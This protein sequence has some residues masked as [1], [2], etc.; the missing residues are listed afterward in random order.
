MAGPQAT[1]VIVAPISAVAASWQQL[2]AQTAPVP[3]DPGQNRARIARGMSGIK[4]KQEL[5]RLRSASTPDALEYMDCSEFVARVLAAAGITPGVQAMNSETLLTLLRDKRRFVHSDT[6][7][8]G[9]VALWAS[10]AGIV[11]ATGTGGTMKLVHAKGAGQLSGE[12]TYAITPEQYRTGSTFY[13][14]FRPLTEGAS[15]G[16]ATAAPGPQSRTSLAPLTP[17]VPVL[18]VPPPPR[19][20]PFQP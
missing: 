19:L 7:R 11:G 16:P 14:Y 6:P 17:R 9:D 8:M 13:G 15:A 1:L 18:A 5:G 20:P 10:H 3:A 12:N 4:Y 2:P